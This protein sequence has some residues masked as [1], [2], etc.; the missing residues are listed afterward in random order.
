MCALWIKIN[1]TPLRKNTNN[2]FILDV[3][4]LITRRGLNELIIVKISNSNKIVY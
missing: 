2:C 1:S 3:S 4:L